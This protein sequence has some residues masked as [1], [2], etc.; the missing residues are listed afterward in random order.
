M[1][2]FFRPLTSEYLTD[3][4]MTPDEALIMNFLFAQAEGF[5]VNPAYLA[6]VFKG[7]IGQDRIKAALKRLR[8]KEHIVADKPRNAKGKFT[9]GLSRVSYAK[10]VHPRASSVGVNTTPTEVSDAEGVHPCALPVG[11]NTTHVAFTPTLTNM[12]ELSSESVGVNTTPTG[13]SGEAAKSEGEARSSSPES[14]FQG[15]SDRKDGSTTARSSSSGSSFP[16]Q[17]DSSSS[18][19]RPEGK[20]RVQV[21]RRTS[22]QGV[23]GAPEADHA[24]KTASPAGGESSVKQCPYPGCSVMLDV[25]APERELLAHFRTHEVPRPKDDMLSSRQ[26]WREDQAAKQHCSDCGK[27]R[28]VQIIKAHH[29]LCE[30]CDYRQNG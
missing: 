15:K 12:K 16:R 26:R 14:S 6:K 23:T 4:T 1:N 29:G 27:P 19:P 17:Y 13:E 30:S 10:G 9:Q 21:P 2:D 3:P 28:P 22:S 8:A 11:V 24:T 25:T 7:R 5:E 20:L 18:S